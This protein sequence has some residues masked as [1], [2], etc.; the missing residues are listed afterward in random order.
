M[1]PV[2]VWWEVYRRKHSGEMLEVYG[3]LMEK[4][5]SFDMIVKLVSS[6]VEVKTA[7]EMETNIL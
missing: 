5:Y 4:H 7:S 6:E 1:V 3:V 2:L